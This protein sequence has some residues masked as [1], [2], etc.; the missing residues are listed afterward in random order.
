M[1]YPSLG[2]TALVLLLLTP[3]VVSAQGA[4]AKV[5]PGSPT[6]DA[7]PVYEVDP[8]WPPTLPNDW[9]WG[10]IRGLFADDNDHLWVIH[11]PSSL[12]PQE[13][14]AAAAIN[15]CAQDY[16]AEVAALT[17]GRGVDVVLEMTGGPVF[18][19]SLAALAPLGRLAVFGMAGRVPPTPVD[20]GRLMARSTAVIGFWLVHVAAHP[21]MMSAALTDLFTL[22]GAGDLRPIE[23]A[24]YSLDTVADAHRSLLDRSS[25]GK[26]VLDPWA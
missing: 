25:V 13:I 10:D 20:P 15:Y 6:A 7:L 19:Q 26:L 23:G 16:V 17:N 3:A 5:A 21:E 11:M 2:R 24:T 8:T 14:G 1:T 12:T 18:D 9:I 22:I 4:T